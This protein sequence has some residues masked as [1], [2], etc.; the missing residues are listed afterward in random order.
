MERREKKYEHDMKKRFG[1]NK[2]GQGDGEQ[3]L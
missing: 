3:Y 1:S 2:E